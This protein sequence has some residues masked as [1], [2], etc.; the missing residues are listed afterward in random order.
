MENGG[1]TL[2]S[3]YQGQPNIALLDK[4]L[5]PLCQKK[6]FRLEEGLG[7]SVVYMQILSELHVLIFNI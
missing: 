3:C 2:A 4:D 6:L 7:K 1:S 5:S